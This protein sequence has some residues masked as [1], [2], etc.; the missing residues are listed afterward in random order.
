MGIFDKFKKSR[1]S[2]S[3]SNEAPS[4][5]HGSHFEAAL[6]NM[7]LVEGLVMMAAGEPDKKEDLKVETPAFGKT[8][9]NVGIKGVNASLDVL[10]LVVNGQLYTGYPINTNTTKYETIVKSVDQ[11]KNALEAWV[12]ANTGDA[13][14]SFFALDYYKNKG[15]YAAGSKL[16]VKLGAF[17]YRVTKANEGIVGKKE[18]FAVDKMCAILPASLKS[19]SAYPDDY[20]F[21]GQVIDIIEFGPNRVFKTKVAIFGKGSLELWIYALG[22]VIT[23]NFKKWDYISG[24]L[25][26]QGLIGKG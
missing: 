22:S 5:G 18:K 6:G 23:G 25:W 26:L 14:L 17:A 7:K 15:K 16:K 1:E 12:T 10:S 8:S 4:G 2:K 13:T 9:A 3:V 24:V 21:Q 19:E 11:W 20:M